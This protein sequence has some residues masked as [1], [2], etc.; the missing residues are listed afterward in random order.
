MPRTRS[1]LRKIEMVPLIDVIFLLLIFFLVTLNIIPIISRRETIESQYAMP[2]ATADESARVDLL[3]QLHQIEGS[4]EVHYFVIDEAF[5]NTPIQRVLNYQNNLQELRKIFNRGG[6]RRA[7][8]DPN[9]IDFSRAK[10][11]I[12]SSNP[13]VPYE[14]VFELIQLCVNKGVKYYCVVSSFDELGA[15]ITYSEPTKIVENYVW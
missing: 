1:G 9:D 6:K 4:P 11:V 5:Q 12:I 13:W 8:D 15:R 7:V 10:R 3:I 14:R 2:V